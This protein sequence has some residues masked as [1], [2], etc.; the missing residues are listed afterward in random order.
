MAGAKRLEVDE[1][2]G[3]KSVDDRLPCNSLLKEIHASKEIKLSSM[4]RR[5][6]VLF[7]EGQQACGI[8]VLRAGR[9]KVSIS[10][11]EGKVVILR[12]AQAGDLLGVNSALKDSPY[13]VTVETLEPCRTDFISRSD[14]I[15][16]LDRSKRARIG[17]NEALSKELTEVVERARS[18]LLPQSAG[19]KLARLLLKWCDEHVAAGTEGIRVNP[20]LTHE[21]MAQMIC[22]SRETV[23]RVFAELKRKRIIS[24]AGSAIFVRN[25]KALE[26][27]ACC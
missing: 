14:F 5:G 17:V 27:L 15:G 13:D 21:E 3:E 20:G 18:L 23:T 1:S 2:S 8:Y 4:H 16:L 25:R 26:S 9:A 19:E 6:V 11:S 10:S 7:S 12:I 22:A 24:L